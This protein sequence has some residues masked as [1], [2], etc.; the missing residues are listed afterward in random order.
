M[1]KNYQTP[2]DS[3]GARN[4]EIGIFDFLDF[5]LQINPQGP[6]KKISFKISKIL[7]EI[8]VKNILVHQLLLV[9]FFNFFTVKIGK[10][11]IC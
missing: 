4:P 7:G 5:Q 3:F 11:M 2:T 10:C 8:S 6:E 1:K 9:I